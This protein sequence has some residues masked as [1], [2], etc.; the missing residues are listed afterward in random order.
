MSVDNLNKMSCQ[1]STTVRQK[2]V[3]YRIVGFG[4][5]DPSLHEPDGL[6]SNLRLSSSSETLAVVVL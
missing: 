2:Q 1:H 6:E 4:G 3:I 5:A